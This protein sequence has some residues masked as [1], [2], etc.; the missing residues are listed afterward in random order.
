MRT[1]EL[2]HQ[3]PKSFVFPEPAGPSSILA[4]DACLEV[5]DKYDVQV[6]IYH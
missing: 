1:G 2:L 4:I 3:V 6:G 5:G